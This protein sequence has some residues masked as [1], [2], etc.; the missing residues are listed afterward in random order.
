MTKQRRADVWDFFPLIKVEI[1]ILDLQSWANQKRCGQ[2][3]WLRCSCDWL[4][5]VQAHVH[6]FILKPIM[7]FMPTGSR[8]ALQMTFDKGPQKPC[9][10]HQRQITHRQSYSILPAFESL[11]LTWPHVFGSVGENPAGS[12]RACKQALPCT[13]S[14]AQ[15]ISEP[16]S[17]SGFQKVMWPWE[18]NAHA[19]TVFSSSAS[20][21]TIAS[22]YVR[23]WNNNG[24]ERWESS[25]EGL[26]ANQHFVVLQ[27]LWIHPNL[28]V[29]ILRVVF[30]NRQW[31][32]WLMQRYNCAPVCR[33]GG[34]M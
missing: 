8:S 6:L 33:F 4:N 27:I 20:T 28:S 12:E 25:V 11:Q 17:P 3:T 31:P 9:T 26:S 34:Q 5:H 14:H 15:I 22:V 18:I 2:S 16:I 30:S 19:H 32:R 10:A 29:W 1:C 13:Y 21:E 23:N 24:G 7:L